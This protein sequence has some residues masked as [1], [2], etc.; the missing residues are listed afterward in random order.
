MVRYRSRASRANDARKVNQIVLFE[1]GV[2]PRE[3]Y[4]ADTTWYFNLGGGTRGSVAAIRYLAEQGPGGQVNMA[5]AMDYQSALSRLED[6]LSATGSWK[7]PL[8][9]FDDGP[10]AAH[11]AAD[12]QLGVD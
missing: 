11:D 7:R 9:D 5:T 2:D 1:G 3:L 12:H 10:P 8:E 6:W 4:V